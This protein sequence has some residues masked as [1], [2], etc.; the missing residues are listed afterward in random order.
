[1]ET[2]CLAMR[3][4]EKGTGSQ[5]KKISGLEQNGQKERCFFARTQDRNEPS[6]G[7][8]QN[9]GLPEQKGESTMQ[10][11]GNCHL[12][13]SGQG[14]GNIMS[15]SLLFSQLNDFMICPPP[16]RLLKSFKRNVLVRLALCTNFHV[17]HALLAP[18][19]AEA[20]Q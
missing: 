15:L 13:Q 3:H 16:G 4:A 1:M 2:R 12:H 10:E 19:E 9:K 11:M 7:T 20:T 17:V 14:K 8:E 18:Q 6:C 5:V